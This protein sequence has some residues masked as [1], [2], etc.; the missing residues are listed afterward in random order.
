MTGTDKH[1]EARILT[2]K[3]LD[4]LELGNESE[5]DKLIEKAK[6]LDPRGAAE[7][8]ADLHEDAATRTQ[9]SQ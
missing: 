9:N 8:V 1:E 3:A 6:K 7:V 5:A 2:E 4:Q